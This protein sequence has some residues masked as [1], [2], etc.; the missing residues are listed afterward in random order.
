MGKII[1][2]KSDIANLKP[3]SKLNSGQF[4]SCFEYNGKVLKI[5]KDDIEPE[6]YRNI[7]RNL[8]RE[9]SVIMYPRD[10]AYLFD[11]IL[12]FKGYLC[13]KAPGTDLL[14]MQTLIK[15][16]NDD[17]SFDNFLAAYYDKF[18][19]ELKKEMV[20]IDDIKLAHIFFKDC[21]YLVD[22]DWYSSIPCDMIVTEKDMRNIRPVNKYLVDFIFSF[23]SNDVFNSFHF[24]IKV[25]NM[26]MEGY[27]EYIIKEIRKVTN[28]EVNTFNEFFHYKFID[29]EEDRKS[30]II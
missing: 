26:H 14:N 25:V 27:I 24:D 19:P 12:Y 3:I 1:L 11:K 4:G 18:L 2:N 9:S 13:N 28:N 16:D 21:F 7:K 6:D 22:T 29:S 30:L 20:L 5:F 10:E 17:I 15:K 23:I 8:K